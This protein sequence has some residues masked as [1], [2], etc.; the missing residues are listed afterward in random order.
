MKLLD[1]L[2][3]VSVQLPKGYEPGKDIPTPRSVYIQKPEP[4]DNEDDEDELKDDIPFKLSKL[5]KDPIT[6]REMQNVEYE[7]SLKLMKKH[8]SKYYNSIKYLRQSKNPDISKSASTLASTLKS[9]V[10]KIRALDILVKT[11]QGE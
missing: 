7:S 8:I 5:Q 11:Y 1:I 3:E 4:R 2:K 9:A 10:E 6:G